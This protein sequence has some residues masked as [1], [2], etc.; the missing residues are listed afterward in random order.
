MDFYGDNMRWF[1]GKVIN[2][3]TIE[4]PGQVQVR[5]FG[6]H[7]ESVPNEDLPWAATMLPVTEGGVSGIGRIPQLQKSALVF[8][9]FMDGKE[10][11]S[12]LILGSLSQIEKPSTVQ[13]RAAATNG[14]IDLSN[15][16]NIGE[17]GVLLSNNL[18][19]MYKEGTASRDERRVIV[20]HFLQMQGLSVKSAAGV[21]GNI[22]QESGFN[23]TVRNS[24]SGSKGL[25]QWNPQ[26]GRLQRLEQYAAR[27]NESPD[28]FFTQ[29]KFLVFDMK[30]GGIHKC[31]NHLSDTAAVTCFEGPKN[32]T[33]AT[34]HFLAVFEKAGI[35]EANLPKREEY[36]R[37][38]YT[39]Y[40][41][42]LAAS[43]ANNVTSAS[44]G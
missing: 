1:V 15:P 40:L 35:A 27:Q 13:Q 17:E 4:A 43:A 18:R 36:A 23:P 34:Y 25:A 9:I 24:S 26:V 22:E 38:A 32:S 6:V 31:W 5:I 11:Q 19:Q 41:D 39:N 10:S 16:I 14:T 44:A 42:S 2:N 30:T 3:A 20:M 12:P 37:L 29:L 21:C 8:G 7:S 28:D 33:N